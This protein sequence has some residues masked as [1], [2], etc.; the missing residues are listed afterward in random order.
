[1]KR[2]FS[3]ATLIVL[4]AAMLSACGFHLRGSTPQDNLPFKSIYFALPAGSP[5]A[6]ELKRNLRGSGTT[7]VTDR[8]AAEVSL[9]P[10]AEKKTKSILSLNAQGRVREFE[11]VYLLRFQLKDAKGKVVLPPTEIAQKRILSYSEAQALA[12]EI[13]EAELYRDMQ[14]DI[15]QQIIRRLAAVKLPPATPTAP[16]AAAP[17]KS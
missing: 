9:E 16:N 11:L 6:V 2:S 4:A 12:R 5:M 3:L 14:S 7:V 15:V 1:M 17:G 13:E 8:K 10:L